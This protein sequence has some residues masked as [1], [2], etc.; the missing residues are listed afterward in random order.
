G[1]LPYQK[2]YFTKLEYDK[3]I[4]VFSA[5]K[6]DEKYYEEKKYTIL[7]LTGIASPKLM[8]KYLQQFSSKI[9]MMTFPDHHNYSTSDIQGIIK[10]FDSIQAE[11]KIIITTEKDSMRFKDNTDISEE[12][13]D[14]L[15]YLPVKVNF[16]EE[17]KKSFNKKIF[18][19]V[20]E[21][22]SN[23]KLHKR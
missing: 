8:E 5:K 13:K 12:I 21:N 18:N 9:E 10:K 7:L 23:R 17:E 22:K 6:L 11:N 1:L 20:G 4:P 14:A 19:Y 3:L 15:Y 16:L 2:L